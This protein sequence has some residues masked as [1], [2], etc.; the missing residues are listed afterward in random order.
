MN[1]NRTFKSVNETNNLTILELGAIRP[2]SIVAKII[3]I[4]ILIYIFSY[5]I[6][7][8]IEP[9][10]NKY[11]PYLFIVIIYCNIPI[12]KSYFQTRKYKKEKHKKIITSFTLNKKEIQIDNSIIKELEKVKIIMPLSNITNIVKFRSY[13][14]FNCK[15]KGYLY[16]CTKNLDGGTEDE[17]IKFLLD[18]CPNLQSN[19]IGHL[20]IEQIISICIIIMA[21]T[22]IIVL[23]K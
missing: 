2:L 14:Y 4:L 23:I 17:A 8:G 1:K 6:K 18:N 16:F 3:Y 21:I 5:A 20:I 10:V 9:T 11:S 13:I 7:N 19:R 12:I 15:D 22:S